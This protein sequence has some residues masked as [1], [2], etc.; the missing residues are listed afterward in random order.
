MDMLTLK[1]QHDAKISLYDKFLLQCSFL[2]TTIYI[3][4]VLFHSTFEMIKEIPGVK[5]LIIR[6]KMRENTARQSPGLI[7]LFNSSFPVD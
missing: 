7:L 4:F 2:H 6:V 3:Q 5:S 1:Y